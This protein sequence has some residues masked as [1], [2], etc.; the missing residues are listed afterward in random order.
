M[1]V[2]IMCGEIAVMHTGR[3]LDVGLC[4]DNKVLQATETQYSREVSVLGL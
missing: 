4:V 1:L 3:R 2:D